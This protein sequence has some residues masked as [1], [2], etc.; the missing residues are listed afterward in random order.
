MS[1]QNSTT[2]T[3]TDNCLS[4]LIKGYGNSNFCLIF[5]GSCLKQKKVICTPPNN[6]NDFIVYKLDT[7]SRDLNFNF[8]LKDWLFGGVRLAKNPDPHKHIYNDCGIGFDSRSELSFPDSS[9]GKGVIIYEVDMSS[10]LWSW[11]ERILI[12]RKNIS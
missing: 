7:H 11:Y 2:P 3:T 8:T 5:Q 4:P 12:I 9:M 10:Y 6:I 1:T